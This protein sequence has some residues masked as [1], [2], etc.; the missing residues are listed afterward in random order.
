MLARKGRWQ[1]GQ[2]GN[3]KG[4]PSTKD[5]VET[6]AR[7]HTEEAVRTLVEL[8][9]HGVPDAVKGAAAN[10]LL[11]RGW[12]MPRQTVGVEADLKPVEQMTLLA[13]EAELARLEVMNTLEEPEE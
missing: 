2:S 5:P 1:P 4:R 3:S 11:N 6:L 8:M 10:A 13:V 9:R 7:E 12:G